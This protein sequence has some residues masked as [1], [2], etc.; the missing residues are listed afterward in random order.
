MPSA[1]RSRNPVETA[2]ALQ[3][4]LGSRTAE[5]LTAETLVTDGLKAWRLA[6]V[7]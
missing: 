2:V 7:S 4:A 5:I 6:N 3:G 1:G